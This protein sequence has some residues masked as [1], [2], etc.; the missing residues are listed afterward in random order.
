MEKRLMVGRYSQILIP[1]LFQ[2]FPKNMIPVLWEYSD[3]PGSIDKWLG[4]VKKEKLPFFIGGRQ[5]GE[6]VSG[7][8]LYL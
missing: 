6:C 1:I 5:L 3:E 2:I 8:R 7:S 4:P